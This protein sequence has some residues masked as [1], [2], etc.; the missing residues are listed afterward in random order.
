MCFGWYRDGKAG[1]GPP[2]LSRAGGAE[3]FEELDE[4]LASEVRKEP[5]E[6]IISVV[7]VVEGVLSGRRKK[8]LFPR[9]LFLARILLVMWCK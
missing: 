2:E 6:R 5:M 3:E 4:R 9:P 7:S 8:S 1:Q